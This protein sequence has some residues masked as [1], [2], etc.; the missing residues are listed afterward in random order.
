MD[1][2]YFNHF[3]IRVNTSKLSTTFNPNSIVSVDKSRV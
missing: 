1:S 2:K 3:N